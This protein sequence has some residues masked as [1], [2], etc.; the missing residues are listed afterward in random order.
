[1]KFGQK[2]QKRFGKP[3]LRKIRLQTPNGKL[4]SL[5]SR[6]KKSAKRGIFD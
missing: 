4:D 2:N 1:M 6:D 5:Q 3:P